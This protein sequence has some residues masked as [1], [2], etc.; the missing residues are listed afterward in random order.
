MRNPEVCFCYRACGGKMKAI[1][2]GNVRIVPVATFGNGG[3]PVYRIEEIVDEQGR[4]IVW[5]GIYETIEGA[6][7]EVENT[8]FIK[9]NTQ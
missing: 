1:R 2:I 4:Y 8:L 6:I 9:V 5:D 7:A 3:I